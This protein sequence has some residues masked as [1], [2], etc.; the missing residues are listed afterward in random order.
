M[1]ASK[2]P[3]DVIS[4]PVIDIH[5]LDEATAVRLE[6][7]GDDN[8]WCRCALCKDGIILE[9]GDMELDDESIPQCLL[10]LRRWS[11]DKQISMWVMLEA[12]GE[13][14]DDLPVYS[15]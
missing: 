7:E 9:L 10:D 13:P 15:W 5:H 3:F 2:Y 14:L 8:P 6:S 1:S 12:L 4:I 11:Q